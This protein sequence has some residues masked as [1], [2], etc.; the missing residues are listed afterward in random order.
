MFYFRTTESNATHDDQNEDPMSLKRN[1]MQRHLDRF[2]IKHRRPK[3]RRLQTHGKS[4]PGA[5]TDAFGSP[6]TLKNIYG[7]VPFVTRNRR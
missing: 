6:P 1:P 2:F 5:H 4:P 3:R 7:T